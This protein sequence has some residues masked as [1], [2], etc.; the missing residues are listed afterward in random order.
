MFT[1]PYILGMIENIYTENEYHIHMFKVL[2]RKLNKVCIFI[3]FVVLNQVC[4]I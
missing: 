1:H 2:R 3:F 4:M